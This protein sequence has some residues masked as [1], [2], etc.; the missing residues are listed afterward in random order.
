MKCPECQHQHPAKYGQTCGRCGYQ[1]AFNPKSSDTIGMTDGKFL[2]FI[3]AA[4]KDGTQYFTGNQLYSAYCRRQSTSRWPAIFFGVIVLVIGGGITLFAAKIL[5]Y[6]M[7]VFGLLLILGAI[8]GSRNV[9]SS[10]QFEQLT[11]KFRQSGKPIEKLIDQPELNEPPPNWPEPDIYDYGVERILIVQRDILVDLFVKN[12]IH[13]TQRTLIISEK[14]YPQYLL[15][16]AVKL[17]EE[18]PDLPVFLLHDATEI[19]TRMKDRLV[20]KDLLPVENHPITDLGLFPED[21]Q[22]L[23]RTKN[24]DSANE[25]RE[26][27]VDALMMPFLAGGLAAAFTGGLAF[28]DLIAQEAATTYSGGSDGAVFDFG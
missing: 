2:S 26:L 16:V 24:F 5:G 10:E 15:P 22:E 27:P 18:R 3:K 21:F 8:L 19:G 7:L 6:G 14:G 1:F 20:R 28:S 9:M 23:K 12:E 11:Q 25:A 4:S 13:T 17:L